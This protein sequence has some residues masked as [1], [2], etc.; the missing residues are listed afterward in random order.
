MA[1]VQLGWNQWSVNDPQNPQAVDGDVVLN[2]IN[3]ILATDP[4]A[5]FHITGHSLGGGLAQYAT[6]DAITKLN[7]APSQLTLT[8][9]NSMGVTD[10]LILYKRDL[11]S[12]RYDYLLSML[13][14]KQAA[15]TLD[16]ND[17]VQAN[18]WLQSP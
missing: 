4:Q 6:Y 17:V 11:A 10:G 2:Y 3:Q 14:L 12:A 7:L 8:T 1:D 5:T 18:G 9:F 13:R 15:G 16:E